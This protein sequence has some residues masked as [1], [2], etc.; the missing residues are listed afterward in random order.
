MIITDTYEDKAGY[1]VTIGDI[2][3]CCPKCGKHEMFHLICKGK[4]DRGFRNGMS[5]IKCQ[6]CNWRGL[7]KYLVDPYEFK[8][9]KRTELID[10]MIYEG[11]MEK[12]MERRLTRISR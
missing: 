6:E 5:F 3:Q 9:K 4:D 1:S 11:K 7:S 8:V 12:N 2:Q 10:R